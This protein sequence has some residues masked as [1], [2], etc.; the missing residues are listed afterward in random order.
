MK[1]KSTGLLPDFAE[2]SIEIEAT[3]SPTDDGVRFFDKSCGLTTVTVTGKALCVYC[4][5]DFKV[6][7]SKEGSLREV[8]R[9]VGKEIEEKGLLGR[10]PREDGRINREFNI[11]ELRAIASALVAAQEEWFSTGR[12]YAKIFLPVFRTLQSRTRKFDATGGYYDQERV[13]LFLPFRGAEVKQLLQLMQSVDYRL[14][15][16][17]LPWCFTFERLHQGSEEPF[18]KTW[19]SCVVVNLHD[20]KM[21]FSIGTP[22]EIESDPKDN[23]VNIINFLTQD[24]RVRISYSLGA[25]ESGRWSDLQKLKKDFQRRFLDT[26]E[27]SAQI[28]WRGI[29]KS[30]NKKAE[31]S[32]LAREIQRIFD[33]P[34]NGLSNRVNAGSLTFDTR[35]GGAVEVRGYVEPNEARFLA[36]VLALI[37]EPGEQGCADLGFFLEGW[38][39]W[40]PRKESSQPL[41]KV[42]EV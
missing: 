27:R 36:R 42:T 19:I 9:D 10:G 11:D 40:E 23:R 34:A 17:C 12:R 28:G 35:E 1:K 6:H 4:G 7:Q 8:L 22:K 15:D 26:A 3:F 16:Y 5:G 2:Y 30:N 24:Q 14:T 18:R 13:A 37:R 39:K 20:G 21:T 33:I 32:N 25:I 38:K 31:A 29:T 41:I